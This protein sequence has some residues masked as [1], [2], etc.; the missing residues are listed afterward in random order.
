[1]KVLFFLLGMTTAAATAAATVLTVLL[2]G[3][4]GAAIGTANALFTAL[5]GMN[6]ISGCTADD[7]NDRRNNQNIR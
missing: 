6:D 3:I 5:F 4:A 7:Q 1:M 2:F